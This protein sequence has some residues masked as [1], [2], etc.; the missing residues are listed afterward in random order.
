MIPFDSGVKVC[1]ATGHTDMRRG[2]PGLALQV[3][4]ILKQDPFCG[5]LFC[6]RGRRSNHLKVI[7][8]DGQGSCTFTKKLERGRFIDARRRTSIAQGPEQSGREFSR[9]AAKTGADDAGFRSVGGLQRF[10]S[11]FSALRNLFV[12]PH[13]KNSAL[14]IHIHRIRA[15]VQWKAVTGATA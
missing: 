14:A 5:H 11:I 8:H 15:M 10:I 4:E 9:A 7:W 13:Q 12:P 1:L 6:F 3:Q 2:F